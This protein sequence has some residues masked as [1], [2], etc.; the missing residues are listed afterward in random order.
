MKDTLEEAKLALAKAKDDMARYYNRRRSPAPTFSPG[1]MV[2]LDS[3]DIQTTRPSKKLSH[4]RLGPYPSTFDAPQ[5]PAGIQSF[6]WIPVEWDCNLENIHR[7]ETE[8][9]GMEP[10]STGMGPESTG[11][12]GIHRND[13]IPQERGSR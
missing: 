2:Y 9:S 6:Q 10:E 3:E 8:S 11:M 5:I 13:R 7:N 12:A 4:R 1:D